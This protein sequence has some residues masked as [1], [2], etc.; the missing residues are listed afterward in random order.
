ML[1]VAAY[2][3]TFI[4]P[5][6]VTSGIVTIRLVNRGKEEHQV[7]FARLDDS[8]SLP[9]VMRSLVADVDHVAGFKWAG[10]VERALPGDSSETTVLLEPGRYVIVCAYSAEDGHAHVSKGMIRELV[11][12]AGASATKL[13]LP[14]APVTIKLTDYR[15]T[16]SG[17]L[18][19]G[20][21][22]VRVENHGKNFHQLT[23]SRFVGN[24]T[25]EELDK[26]D[27]KSKP[28]PIEGVGG[29][30]AAMGAGQVSLISIALRPGR[31][32]L[33]CGLRDTAGA[34]P[35]FMLGM[36]REIKVK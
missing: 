29:G 3:Y 7:T 10:G 17:A 12:S 22:M 9:R 2:E 34:K 18:R 19:S 20:Q 4:A 26:W 35:H 23:L 25:M 13:A 8:S 1:I 21:Q 6:S 11:V 27:G 15:I 30:A 36:E 16:I 14:A 24:G 5:D 32:V 28:T 31:Y 33:D